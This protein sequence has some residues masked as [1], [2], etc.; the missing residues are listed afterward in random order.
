MQAEKHDGDPFKKVKMIEK[1][2]QKVDK[3]ENT[4][5]TVLEI[6]GMD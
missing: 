1:K 6:V 4:V 3:V 5:N 2:L